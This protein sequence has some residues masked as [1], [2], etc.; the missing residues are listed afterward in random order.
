MTGESMLFQNLFKLLE[1]IFIKEDNFKIISPEMYLWNMKPMQ[2]NSILLW[3]LENISFKKL[4][5]IKKL[6]RYTP[7][8][9]YIV[10][11]QSLGAKFIQKTAKE[12]FRVLDAHK[13]ISDDKIIKMIKLFKKR[14]HMILISSDS[15]FVKVVES[16][17]KANKLHWILEDRN[18]K[19][20]M[21]HINLTNKN[22]KISTIGLH[23]KKSLNR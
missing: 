7:E 5:Q 3:D 9:M 10:T 17:T 15:D 12:H 14:S 20:I 16:Y 13:T 6:V 2:E 19:A 11:K 4:E 21:M 22:L 23:T 1:N 18:K 8:E